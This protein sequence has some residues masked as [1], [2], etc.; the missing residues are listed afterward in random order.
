MGKIRVSNRNRVAGSVNGRQFMIFCQTFMRVKSYEQNYNQKMRKLQ[1]KFPNN[2]V[3]KFWGKHHC[4]TMGP[5]WGFG[6]PFF[7]SILDRRTQRIAVC[8]IVDHCR[9]FSKPMQGQENWKQGIVKMSFCPRCAC[10]NW[11]HIKT[12]M[13]SPCVKNL[14]SIRFIYYFNIFALCEQFWKRRMLGPLLRNLGP[15]L[16]PFLLKIGSP[17]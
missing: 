5:L 2:K 8:T 3:K 16:V 1:Q 7:S 10:E 15:L 14:I 17:F 13:G 11:P 6:S 12:L 4:Y 9:V